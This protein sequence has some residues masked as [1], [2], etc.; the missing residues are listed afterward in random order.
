MDLTYGELAKTPLGPISF[1]AG[2]HGLRGLCFSSL[3]ML[4][5]QN[6]FPEG[7]PSLFGLETV[8]VLLSELNE[9]LFG[10]R[11][12]FTLKIDWDVFD[13]FQ[14]NVLAFTSEIP[15]G[16]VMT[17]GDIAKSL[18]KPGSARAVGMALGRNPMPIVIPCHRVIGADGG[19][20][21]YTNGIES[22]AFLLGLEGHI[23]SEGK[24]INLTNKSG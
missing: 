22:K 9:Y 1:Y 11:K 24:L 14:Q 13:G 16:E 7:K 20:R 12:N 6:N 8:G 19:L 5:A 15:Y 4:K 23:I 2:D 10:I 3:R 17:Y 18:G 21:G